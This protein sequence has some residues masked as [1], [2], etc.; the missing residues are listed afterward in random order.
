MVQYGGSRLSKPFAS[1][2]RDSSAV[3]SLTIQPPSAHAPVKDA[4]RRL[5]G[6]SFVVILDRRYASGTVLT[7][8]KGQVCP[9]GLYD[10][11]H[12]RTAK[13][14]GEDCWL[15]GIRYG[16][17]R[18]QGHTDRSRKYSTPTPQTCPHR[19]EDGEGRHPP[20]RASLPS[21]HT[22]STDRTRPSRASLSTDRSTATARRR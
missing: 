5:R 10:S 1:Q 16:Q 14:S 13:G 6:D 22:R 18:G 17:R 21:S 9:S 20:S 19:S 8:R 15:S 2:G 7:S 12:N 4:K 3:P 11:N